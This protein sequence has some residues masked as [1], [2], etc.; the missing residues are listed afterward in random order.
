MN[1]LSRYRQVEPLKLK[2]TTAK[3]DVFMKMIKNKRPRKL[4]VDAGTEFNG[5]FSTLCQKNEIEFYETFSETKQEL[6]RELY[7]CSR[8]WYTSI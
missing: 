1:Y 2:W 8:I 7:D 6:R 5:S 3:A 4:L